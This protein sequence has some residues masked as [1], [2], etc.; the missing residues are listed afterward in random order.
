MKRYYVYVL[1]RTEGGD[2]VKIGMTGGVLRRLAQHK[3]TGFSG[4][5]YLERC[6]SKKAALTRER[7]LH[8]RFA[9][10]RLGGEWFRA[11]SV[12][13]WLCGAPGACGAGEVEE[14]LTKE[15][16]IK[17]AIRYGFGHL[18]PGLEA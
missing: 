8:S 3:R 6:D 14:Q 11:G 18:V 17:A 10:D 2:I 12:R 15:K 13:R 1:E 16:T 4:M 9:D 7:E 5:I